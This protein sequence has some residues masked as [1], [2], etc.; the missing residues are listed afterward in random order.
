MVILKLCHIYLFITDL[1]EP[2]VYWHYKGHDHT[3]V[4]WMTIKTGAFWKADLKVNVCVILNM[5]QN[6]ALY[7]LKL[8][9]AKF[10]RAHT[11]T[12]LLE[13]QFNADICTKS[14][15]SINKCLLYKIM[16]TGLT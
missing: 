9:Y 7:H 2:F 12:C 16:V 15:V 13:K 1:L 3:T 10:Y 6:I 5:S 8:C 14:H 11:Q 4:R